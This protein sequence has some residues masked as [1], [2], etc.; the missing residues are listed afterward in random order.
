MTAFE[1]LPAETAND[2]VRAVEN[3]IVDNFTAAGDFTGEQGPAVVR[4]LLDLGWTAPPAKP[5]RVYADDEQHVCPR[6]VEA[7]PGWLAQHAD[8][9]RWELRDGRRCCSWC[10]STNPDDLMAALR[11]GAVELGPTDKSYKA[12]VHA[13]PGGEHQGKFYFQHLS[14]EQQVEFI[15][16]VNAKAFPIGFPGRFYVLPFFARPQPTPLGDI[17]D[18]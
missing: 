12:Y 14:R 1:A 3:A 13:A 17:A 11:D 16:L 6:R 4:A 10:G 18:T 15:D 5:Q 2:A 8:H 9:D 7:P